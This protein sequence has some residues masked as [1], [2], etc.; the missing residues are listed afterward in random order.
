M[1]SSS[2]GQEV[3]VAPCCP[4]MGLGAGH[5]STMCL[6]KVVWDPP[7]HN[8]APGEE[9]AGGITGRSQSHQE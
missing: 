6:P 3:K 7:P 5:I 8:T 9:R 4:S 2:P 1:G